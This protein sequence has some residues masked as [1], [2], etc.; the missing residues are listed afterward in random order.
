MQLNL[1]IIK[2]D[3]IKKTNKQMILFPQKKKYPMI[4]KIK[5]IVKPKFLKSFLLDLILFN[6]SIIISLIQIHFSNQNHFLRFVDL[7]FLINNYS[8]IDNPFQF[9]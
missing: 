4:N 3:P 5:P 9:S 6:S 8:I 1:E 7:F 2:I